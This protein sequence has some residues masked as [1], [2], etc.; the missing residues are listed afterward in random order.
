MSTLNHL[1]AVAVAVCLLAAAPDRVDSTRACGFL[2]NCTDLPSLWHCQ[3]YMLEEAVRGGRINGILSGAT[4]REV[5]LEMC[6]N[7]LKQI[8]AAEG[9]TCSGVEEAMRRLVAEQER[10][11]EVIMGEEELRNAWDIAEE[12][13]GKCGVVNSPSRCRFNSRFYWL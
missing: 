5:D 3:Q 2:E 10:R 4:R 9:S 13:P 1:V 11:G 8:E 7:K 6:C 12:L